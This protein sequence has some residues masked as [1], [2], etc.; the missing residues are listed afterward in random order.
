V[1][2]QTLKAK[3]VPCFV[4]SREKKSAGKA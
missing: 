4:W 1:W 3:G 2:L